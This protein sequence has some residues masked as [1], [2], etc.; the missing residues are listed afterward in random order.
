MKIDE[1]LRFDDYIEE[2][3]KKDKLNALDELFVKSAKYQNSHVYFNLLNFINRFPKLSPFNAFLIHMQNSGVEI[4]LSADKWAKY[5]RT[6]KYNSRPLVILI[7][8]GPV[9]FIYD[10]SDT[11]GSELPDYIK[12]PFNT[13]GNLDPLIYHRTVM[14]CKKENISIIEYD[15]YKSSAGYAQ[16]DVKSFNVAL[17]NSYGTNEKYSTFVH[18][19]AHIFCGHLGRQEKRWW[20]DR[21]ILS[22]DVKEI[23]A[24]SISFLVC[25]RLGLKTTSEA[26]LSSYINN[27]NN[28]P[29][30]SLDTILTVSGYI[31]QMGTVQ[32]KSKMK[33]K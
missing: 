12:H 1:Q 5:N 28:M 24:E 32:F 14:S 25:K 3:H 18:E 30:I 4:V 13:S 9:S 31:E 15:M 20:K 10:I 21:S 17:N 26:Y 27:H 33:K 11:E 7:P 23:E 16:K 2:S 29:T 19:L 8:F 22:K 6:I